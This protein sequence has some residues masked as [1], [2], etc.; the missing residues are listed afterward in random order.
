MTG[1]EHVGAAISECFHRHSRATDEIALVVSLRQI[2][3]MMANDDANDVV[4]KRAEY[5]AHGRHLFLVD[6]SALNGEGTCRVDTKNGDS[7]VLV[8]RSQI[9]GDEAPVLSQL[10]AKSRPD[11]VKR[12][13]MIARHNNLR[14]RQAIEKRAR[15][16][17]LM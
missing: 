3:R 15:F 7:V 12:H 6:S 17:K 14:R 11:I 2:K 9:S 5:V 4:I 16:L 1:K 8:E 10:F 13:I